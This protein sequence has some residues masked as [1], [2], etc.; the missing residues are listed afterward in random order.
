MQNLKVIE[1]FETFLKGVSGFESEKN[2][3]KHFPSTTDT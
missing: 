1:T 2:H 3:Y